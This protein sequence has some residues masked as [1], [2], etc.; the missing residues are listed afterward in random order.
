MLFPEA[1]ILVFAKPPVAGYA[2]TRLIPKLGAE[3]AAELHRKLCL[4]T[5]NTVTQSTLCPVELWCA[6]NPD[7]AFFHDC[8][9][10]YNVT[11]KQQQGNDL[12]QR[13]AHALQETLK[14]SPFA[15]LIGCDCPSL[16][17]DDLAT[18]LHALQNG[19]HCVLGPAEDG[20]YVLIGLSCFDE[21]LFQNIHWGSDSVLD[22]TRKILDTLNWQWQ[23]TNTHCD[24]DRPDDLHQLDSLTFY[25]SIIQQHTDTQ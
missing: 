22:E 2:K 21:T 25:N 8:K 5:L 11:L 3:A 10:E 20:G 18:A 23:E 7:H 12:G 4:H 14:T 16:T 6:N 19:H 24:I 17:S 13:M 15:I 1:R 9:K